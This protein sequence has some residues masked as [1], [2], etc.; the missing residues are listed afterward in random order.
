EP[1][2][3]GNVTYNYIDKDAQLGY[4]YYR[5]RGIDLSGKESYTQIAKVFIAETIRP[6]IGIYPNPITNGVVN[7]QL[8]NQPA[9]KYGIRL[10]NPVGQVIVSKQI[11]LAGGNHTE[12]IDWDYKLAH[13]MYQLEVTKPDGGLHIIKV[14]Y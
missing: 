11:T 13:G 3:M 12:K 1:G 6:S 9:G 14:M 2:N 5:I 8:V 10:V 7:L 4:H